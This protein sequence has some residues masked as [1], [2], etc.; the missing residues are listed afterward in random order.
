MADSYLLNTGGDGV[1]AIITNLAVKRLFNL[2]YRFDGGIA[3]GKIYTAIDED[4]AAWVKQQQMFFVSTA[5]LAADGLV[6]CSPKGLDTLVILDPHTIAYLD[7]TGSGV[8]TIAH[9]KENGRIVMM[10]CAFENPARIVRFH[11]T[12]QAILLDDPQFDLLRPSFPEMA[13]V[14]SI[15][16]I[17]VN[18]I[19]DS[20][21]YGV[22]LYEYK[23]QRKT[24]PK[25]A[26]NKGPE[27]ILTYQAERNQHS[28]D[29]LPALATD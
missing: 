20:C 15:I 16:K 24:Y 5:P 8:E 23:G 7:L 17:V 6:N 25:H 11:G 26:A 1:T 4:M 19:A 27:G 13:G 18:R 3:M 22:P 10:F 28:L 9:L 12:G 21:G 29:G 14:R 2:N